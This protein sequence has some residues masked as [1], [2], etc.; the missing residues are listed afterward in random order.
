MERGAIDPHA[1]QNRRQL[2]SQGDLGT[3]QAAPLRHIES[4]ALRLENR[5]TRLSMILAAS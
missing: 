1:V 4:P 5:V 2:A 3:F